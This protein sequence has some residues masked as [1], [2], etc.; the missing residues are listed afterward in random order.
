MPIY[1]IYSF[2]IWK[3]DFPKINYYYAFITKQM[4]NNTFF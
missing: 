1:K 3:W 2:L 4:Q